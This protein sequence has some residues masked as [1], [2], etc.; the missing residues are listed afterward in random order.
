MNNKKQKKWNIKAVLM[1]DG[2]SYDGWQRLVTEGKN[3][4]LQYIIEQ[5]LSDCIKEEVKITGS[6]RTDKGVHALHQVINFSSKTRLDLDIL[7]NEVNGLLP[8]DIKVLSMS[9]ASIN[10]HS[11]FDAKK[12]TYEYR[13]VKE[14]NQSVFT[15]KYTY[16]VQNNI[17]IKAMII[18]AEFLIGTHDFKA[19]STDKKDKKSTVRTIHSIE[20]KNV[21]DYTTKY[22][23]EIRI[24]IT[25][26]GFLYNMV[27]IIVGTLVEVGEGK[28]SPIDVKNILES[29]NR[30][31]A[32]AT[33]GCQGLFLKK[34]DY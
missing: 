4:S 31:L 27:R 18:G 10:F 1:Y 15:R 32:G 20:I 17:D 21:C 19:Y 25:G 34:V 8:E 7:K 30:S 16:P 26:N 23:D 11:R 6:G 33:I 12:K 3:K 14:D 9:Y 24:E 2:S 5:V 28:K 13:L 22:K 29:K